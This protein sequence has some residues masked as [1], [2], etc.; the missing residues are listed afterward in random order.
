MPWKEL[1]CCPSEEIC[2]RSCASAVARLRLATAWRYCTKAV[3]YRFAMRAA[4]D[5]TRLVAV[6][7]ITFV[8]PTSDADTA[9]V[10][11]SRSRTAC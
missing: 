4:W 5:G 1:S 2:E 9:G 6:M 7:A 8:W 11:F 10:L 3:A